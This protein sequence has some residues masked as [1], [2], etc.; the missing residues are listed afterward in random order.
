MANPF[1]LFYSKHLFY[2]KSQIS[3]ADVSIGDKGLPPGECSHWR[4]FLANQQGGVFDI[5]KA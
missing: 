5:P 1:Y 2:L 4:T 3:R